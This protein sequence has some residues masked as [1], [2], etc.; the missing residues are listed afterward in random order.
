MN[1][2]RRS[3][4]STDNN[5]E[6]SLVKTAVNIAFREGA[7]KVFLFGSAVDNPSEASDIDLAIEGIEDPQELLELAK[8]IEETIQKPVDIIDLNSDSHRELV[9]LIT[10][11][12]RGMFFYPDGSMCSNNCENIPLPPIKKELEIEGNR[13][14]QAL[15]AGSRGRDNLERMATMSQAGSSLGFTFGLLGISQSVSTVFVSVD[16]ACKRILKRHQVPFKHT[17]YSTYWLS[18]LLADNPLHHHQHSLLSTPPFPSFSLP[19][20]FSSDTWLLVDQ[21]KDHHEW[22]RAISTR[23]K[24]I[25]I[26]R[27]KICKS[28]DTAVTVV[29]HFDQAVDNFPC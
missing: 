21:L 22:H 2:L 5:N 6:Y 28:L 11:R 14:K 26:D 27:L 7:S 24:S 19:V 12:Y 10:T 29:D 9:E 20:L 15:R 13:M 3:L 4:S 18:P 16:N 23:V 25:E 17:Y 1:A 8:I